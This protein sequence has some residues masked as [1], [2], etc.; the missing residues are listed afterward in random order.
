MNIEQPL[1]P[2]EIQLAKIEKAANVLIGCSEAMCDS[3][4][5]HE[6]LWDK[7]DAAIPES[8]FTRDQVQSYA[9]KG[10]WI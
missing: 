3:E 4:Y 1:Q 5:G 2:S 9:E 6:L 10:F 8:G 7:I